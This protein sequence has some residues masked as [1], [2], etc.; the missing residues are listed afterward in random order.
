MEGAHFAKTGTLVSLSEQWFVDCSK[1]NE[2]C[3]G[4]DQS[5]AFEYAEKHF[6]ILEADYKYKDKD[7][8]CKYDSTAHTTIQVSDYKMVKPNSPA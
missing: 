1:E 7:G 8:T 3:D 6:A 2:G 5:L 4:G